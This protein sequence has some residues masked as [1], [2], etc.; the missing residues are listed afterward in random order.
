MED[1][2]EASR[3]LSQIEELVVST[4]TEAVVKKIIEVSAGAETSASLS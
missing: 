4:E 3:R 2:E 1:L